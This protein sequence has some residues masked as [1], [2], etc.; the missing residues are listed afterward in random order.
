MKISFN[1]QPDSKVTLTANGKSETVDLWGRAHKLLQGHA[2]RVNVYDQPLSAPSAGQ[3]VT[4]S[5]GKTTLSLL[6]ETG[7]AEVSVA[8]PEGRKGVVRIPARAQKRGFPSGEHYWLAQDASGRFK[9]EPGLR[10][11]RIYVSAAPAGSAVP[12][13]NKAAI[14][15]HAGVAESVVTGSWLAARPIY[16]GSEAMPI[17][18]DMRGLLTAF[19]WAATQDP[20]SDWVLYQRGHAYTP[21]APYG[22]HWMRGESELHPIV[23]GAYGT[24]PR[25]IITR[26]FGWVQLGPRFLLVRD[27]QIPSFAPTHGYGVIFENLR[28]TGE[29]EGQL[30]QVAMATLREVALYDYAL[31]KPRT[32]GATTWDGS[33]DRMGGLYGS[34]GYNLLL[35]SCLV[36]RN[37]WAEGYDYN[38]SATK[39]M[40]TSNRNHGLYFQFD[41]RDIHLRD[42]MI[43]RNASCGVQI[44]VGGQY[45]RNL[46]ADNNI[47]T[48][49]QWG[50]KL[51]PINQFCNFLDNVNFG[52]GY[53]RVQGYEG[54]INWGFDNSPRLTAKVGNVIAH[55]ADPD[56]P[57]EIAD[58]SAK[59]ASRPDYDAAHP[60]KRDTDYIV[61]DTQ[62][63][64]WGKD[65][66]GAWKHERIDGLNDTVL[67][68]TTLQRFA[69][70]KTGKPAGQARINDLVVH[71]RD[72]AENQIGNV[73]R[74]AV[75]W[76]K[77]RFGRPLPARTAAADLVFRPDPR[78]DG[79]RWDNR[80]NWSS[81]DLPGSHV[82]DS[83]DL[84]GHDV[85]F[86]TLDRGIAAMASKGGSLDVT[87]GRLTVGAITDPAAVTVRNSGQFWCGATSQPIAIKAGGGRVNLT[88][89]VSRLDLEARGRAEV[90]LGSSA[91]VPAGQKLLVSGQRTLAGWDGTGSATLTVA[92]TLE[93]R[94]GITL[95][96]SG[97]MQKQ[98]IMRYGRRLQ[99]ASFAA[100]LGDYEERSATGNHMVLTDL[101]GMPVVG[102]T[103]E[104][105]II[106]QIDDSNDRLDQQLATVT[107]ILSRGI[108]RLQRFRSGTI[109][110]GTVEPT[111]AASVV[112]ARGS[113]VAI[114]G[115]EYL[116]PGSHDLTGPGVTVTNQGATLPAGVTVTGGKLVLV[117]S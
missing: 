117:V 68:Q 62:V 41:C 45:E 47:A 56:N 95:A 110:D 2:G 9:P 105:G 78:M 84:D 90:L 13:M 83:V 81:L 109:G 111:V 36:D 39:P 48:G 100:T 3:A 116:T 73:V 27:L 112:L 58:R 1:F 91:T 17:T 14:A 46:F 59:N 101:T 87:S 113:S 79:F 18:E 96:V 74:Q 104:F 25:P 99:N 102:E 107:A 57:A 97:T 70:T 115:R 54:G 38:R 49:I 40:A 69:A 23:F 44:R 10:H 114:S 29:H 80:Y 33:T 19:L 4:R 53:K 21:T 11:R 89:A 50:T 42:N 98:R 82:A 24:G 22:A 103:F 7:P 108:P 88:G 28:Q 64:K 6:N 85:L 75:Q 61:N 20:R 35:D 93:F 66:T 32:P 8:L 51:G 86:G 16:G 15:A 60:Y 31:A 12:A 55:L 94:A 92:G 65:I 5:D 76:T 106:E 43:S 30:T 37:G 72:H 34:H 63:Y 77:T 71:A 26:G 52:A 67:N